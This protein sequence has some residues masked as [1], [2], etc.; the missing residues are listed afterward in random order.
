ML[1]FQPGALLAGT[2]ALIQHDLLICFHGGNYVNGSILMPPCIEVK[3]N[4]IAS[5]Q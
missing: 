3:G 5:V 2:L 1:A 4:N